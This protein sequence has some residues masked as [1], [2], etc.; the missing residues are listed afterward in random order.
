MLPWDFWLQTIRIRFIE[1]WEQKI[2]TQFHWAKMKE[3]A[4]LLP[5]RWSYG[6]TLPWLSRLLDAAHIPWL[7]PQPSEASPRPLFPS[8]HH[9]F[10]LW[11]SNL[12]L[13]RMCEITMDPFRRLGPSISRALT[14]KSYL[15]CEVTKSQVA[16]IMTWLSLKEA[17]VLPTTHPKTHPPFKIVA[18]LSWDVIYLSLL[19]KWILMG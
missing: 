5:P 4:G 13:I 2:K 11:P 17:I 3:L 6:T 1:L 9:P 8:S 19:Q 15:P 18:S 16:G 12:A 14:V 10:L 7:I